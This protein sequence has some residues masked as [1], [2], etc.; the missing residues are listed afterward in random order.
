MHAV[1]QNQLGTLL[2]EKKILMKWTFDFASQIF[3]VGV[4]EK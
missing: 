4:K 1:S 2:K 3:E